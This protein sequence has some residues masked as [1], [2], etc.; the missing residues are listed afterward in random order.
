MLEKGGTAEQGYMGIVLTFKRFGF[1]LGL[2]YDFYLFPGSNEF[3]MISIY[4]WVVMNTPLSLVQMTSLGG[5]PV[6]L[7]RRSLI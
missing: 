4:F 2:C 6:I 5:L 1:S 3:A 7:K